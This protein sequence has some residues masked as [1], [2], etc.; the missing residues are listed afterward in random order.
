MS[1]IVERKTALCRC[2]D[3]PAVSIRDITTI[4]DCLIARSAKF[5]VFFSRAELEAHVAF[6]M[7]PH[8]REQEPPTFRIVLPTKQD[9]R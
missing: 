3:L 9:A 4:T 2:H 7:A 6:A 5:N 8:Y 1:E